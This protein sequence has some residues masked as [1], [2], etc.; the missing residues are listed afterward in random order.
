[1]RDAAIGR[2]GV[3]NSADWV[4]RDTHMHIESMVRAVSDRLAEVSAP[5]AV[6]TTAK[7]EPQDQIDLPI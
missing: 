6:D 3:G 4:A 2:G 5:L 7:V 1:V